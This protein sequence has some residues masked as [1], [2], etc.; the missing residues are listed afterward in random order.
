[1]K[2]VFF[3][4]IAIISLCVSSLT[5]QT[6]T[7]TDFWVTFG[8]IGTSYSVVPSQLCD[9]HVRIVG[10]SFPTSGT[11]YFTELGTDTTFNIAPYEVYTYML[12]NAEK[13]AVYN[14]TTGT[15]NFSIHIT[16]SN[17]VSIY[18]SNH[19]NQFNDISNVLPVT[20]LGTDY[21]AISWNN[22]FDS[23]AYA[24]IATENDTRVSHNGETPITLAAGQVYYRESSN[25]QTGDHITSDKPVAFFT[26]NR[27]VCIP[28][29][30]SV[31]DI[32][33]QQLAPVHTW[34]KTFFVPVTVIELEYVRIVASQNGTNIT[35]TGGILRDDLG[36]ASTL[37]NLNAGDYVTLE[38]ALS[39]NGCFIAAD[40]PVGVCSFMR[41]ILSGEG[42]GSASEAWIPAIEQSIPTV[43]MTPFEQPNYFYHYAIVITPTATKTNTTVSTEGSAPVLLSGGNWYDN[44]DAGMSFYNMP[45]PDFSASY[46]F[47]N[48]EGVMVFGYGLNTVAY[49]TAASSYYYLAGS[50]M[51]NLQMSFYVNGIHYEDLSSEIIT[52]PNINFHAEIEDWSSLRW[53]IDDV[54]YLPA[55]DELDWSITFAPGIYNLRMWAQFTGGNT[56]SISAI[57]NIAALI[58][59]TA[60]P[61]TAGSVTGTGY[62]EVGETATLTAIPANACY[63]FLYWA[64]EFD[65][66]LTTGN[67]LYVTVEGDSSFV[68]HFQLKTYTITPSV[69]GGN[70]AIAP[71]ATTSVDCGNNQAFTFTPD[72][73]YEL[74]SVS[75]DGST[76][77][78]SGIGVLSGNTFTF[79]NVTANHTL[80][81]T[82]SKITY[83]IIVLADPP[84]GGDVSGG[85]TNIGCDSLVTITAANN[86]CTIIF[87][88]WSDEND[89]WVSNDDT[90]RYNVHND[91]TFI[92]HFVAKEYD[93][94]ATVA[95]VGSGTVSG[96][97]TGII[98]GVEIDVMATPEDCFTFLYWTD[99]DDNWIS[100][101]DML[102]FIV[103]EDMNLVA[104]FEQ[105]LYDVVASTDPTD[106]GTITGDD[107]DI[108]CGTIIT[109]TVTENPGFTFLYWTD[110]DDNWISDDF[111]IDITV[112]ENH[113]LI[114]VFE[115]DPSNITVKANPITGGM[116][117][118]NAVN[119]PYGTERTVWSFPFN[120]Y[121]FVNWTDLDGSVASLLDTFTFVVTGSRTL[122]ANFALKSYQVTTTPNTLDMGTTSGDG[123]YEIGE[124]A[125]V[126]ATPFLPLYH[127]VNWTDDDG[128]VSN[129]NPYSFPVSRD[130][131]LTA[132]FAIQDF[133]VTVLPDP[134]D[135]GIVSGGGSHIPF[136]TLI[137]VTATP[138]V[139]YTFL[140]WT[141]N[142]VPKSVD[143]SY[144]FNVTQ[145]VTVVA[146]F[147]PTTCNVYVFTSSGA[148]GTVE[149]D[150]TNIPYGAW[151]TVYAYPNPSYHFVNWTEDGVPVSTDS[152]YGFIVHRS[153][154]LVANFALNT[155]DI[156]LKAQP[157][158]GGI[159][160]GGGT[161]IPHGT[162]IHASATA[163]PFFTFLYWTKENGDIVATDPVFDFNATSD[164][165]L[166]AHF[167]SDTFTVTLT[168]EPVGSGTLTGGGTDIPY[169]TEITVWAIPDSCHNFI[170]WIENGDT[171]SFTP[172]YTFEVIGNHELVAH[173]EL[174]FFRVTAEV[175]PPGAGIVSFD[176][177]YFNCGDSI[178]LIATPNI[179]YRFLNWTLEGV[180]VHPDSIYGFFVTDSVDLVAN[181][182]YVTYYIDLMPDP[183]G[184]GT[185]TQSGAYPLNFE[186]TV[187]AVANPEYTFVN[188]TE[189]EDTVCTTAN[190]TFTVDRDRFLVAHFE[191]ALFDVTVAPSPGWYA[192]EVYGDTTGLTYGTWH[193]I[194][195]IP[196]QYFEF[197]EWTYQDGTHF[198]YHAIDS[199]PVHQT[200]HLVAH[201]APQGCVITLG[202]IPT[203]GGE[204]TG[205]GPFAYG[206]VDTIRAFPASD[207]VF[208]KWTE[209]DSIISNS[210]MHYFTVYTSRHLVA[211]FAPKGFTIEVEPVPYDWGEVFGGGTYQLEQ[212]ANVSA[213]AFPNYAFDYWS[214]NGEI[215][216]GVDAVYPFPVTCDRHLKAHFKYETYNVLIAP[217]N[218]DYGW[219]DGGGF[220]IPWG[221]DTAVIAGPFPNY[222]F[223][224][225]MEGSD[226]VSKK[227][228]YD[229]TVKANHSFVAHF[230]PKMYYI[231]LV[232]EPNGQG[233]VDGEGY[234]A[235]LDT[236]T[237]T[238]TPY[239][240]Y[241][242]VN[243]TEN[244]DTLYGAGAE[245]TFT[246]NHSRNLVANFAPA[247]YNIILTVYLEEG[248]YTEGTEFGVPHGEDRTVHAIPF[249]GSH[250]IKWT[251]DDK[252]VSD[253]ADYTFTVICSRYLVAHFTAETR[254]ITLISIPPDGGTLT[255][256]GDIPLGRE[257]TISAKPNDCYE[258]VM[259]TEGDSIVS[260]EPDYTFTIEED[261]TFLA[262]FRKT[263]VSIFTEATPP[264]G[265]TVEGEFID[266]AC[267]TP[268]TIRAFPNDE[269]QFI[270][271]T[272]DGE[273]FATE[274]IHTFDA[275]GGTFVAH[276]EINNY[277]ITL[278]ADPPDLGTVSGGGTFEYGDTITVTA[279][280][281]S[282][283]SLISW[284]ENGNVVST[285]EDYTFMVDRSRTLTAHFE[286]TRYTVI[287]IA[288][289]TI[290]G[291]VKGGGIFDLNDLVEVQ[292]F[293][294]LGYMFANWTINDVVVSSKPV[295]E[296]FVTE[297]V[298]I[299]A[300]F[301]GLDFD[302]YA[303]TLWDNTFMLNMNK[304]ASKGY[305]IIGCKWFKNGKEE[306]HTNTI[307][308]FSY[309]A[310]PYETDLLELAPTYYMFML[311]T[312]N[313]TL[314]Y[315]TKKM[316]TEY[317]F[318]HE[319]EEHKIMVYP[320]PVMSGMPF[321]LEGV[322][323]GSAIEVYNQYGVCV[324]KI[325]AADETATLSLNLPA[326]VYII[327]N[328][329]KTTR[330]TIIR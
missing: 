288:N 263:N 103:E 147:I 233:T 47:S 232:A 203:I 303:A 268:V 301:Y 190:Y 242:F 300:N 269:Y 209:N 8:Q 292:A 285:D 105:Q 169:L 36:G 127:F 75:V 206:E 315:S 257:H 97:G 319:P 73:C 329:Y 208:V 49:S 149:G 2:K 57:V 106:A 11:I 89:N 81:V 94:L 168:A 188:W 327:R 304:L 202:R 240:G 134:E 275:V 171:V 99:E 95:P 26:L 192:G 121:Y 210:P 86:D 308:E 302:T 287:A 37:N 46:I 218:S 231:D 294:N 28:L 60:E 122:T 72:N 42:Q 69:I 245:Y 239:E 227:P 138:L 85:G 30:G 158:H 115:A 61:L 249:E 289:D 280:A 65:N 21:Y 330:I 277:T 88:H 70:G 133:S 6:T 80:D 79:N 305:D 325:N 131:D 68:A 226:T 318:D 74:N 52:T 82:F 207:Y 92:A 125:T 306:T 297:N 44:V 312:K 141:I 43:L 291:K 213:Q 282:G 64:D 139:G 32:I 281:K 317:R 299:V 34:G 217:N 250:F 216:S 234:Y 126:T 311:I 35:Q 77:I 181:F 243:W 150:T 272:R 41:S 142:D 22:G 10:G 135:G 84:T 51:R 259:W 196:A 221:T 170:C 144:S 4:L 66:V 179:G 248:G 254:H 298:T 256:G 270:N 53:F 145:S 176:T 48:P 262:H 62:Y 50:G 161:G 3:N 5:A 172:D 16:A 293:P 258:F 59:A 153:R 173:F 204:V 129:S 104:H 24:V 267:G 271:W 19:F 278:V 119:V 157:Q 146:H 223:L 185:A 253:D 167:I 265:G 91:S 18:A 198:S 225:W 76:T 184:T 114:A 90:L 67:P 39:N 29:F 7:G 186:L 276:F 194:T 160:S 117:G 251:E 309:S 83:E 279:S 156:I 321:K 12:D 175:N 235:F 107:T 191:D 189:D 295:Y 290:Y 137:T 212:T 193:T 230:K 182:E 326:G 124:L 177:A 199:F 222:D 130:R 247:S 313:G 201:F 200:L 109:V 9:M 108:P 244:G 241:V 323:K 273:E 87:S 320:N 140:Y 143:T 27:E 264:E 25:I 286:K 195:A 187:K 116:A 123:I 197:I 307:D 112:T 151:H 102:T 261:K 205:A 183:Y 38:I 78:P 154:D 228:R 284:T 316:L 238:A 23:D 237:I 55:Q 163:N 211:H 255:G 96:D 180:V 71:N 155:Y 54:E 174:M 20:A 152:T 58:E 111:S 93:I 56:M 215:L 1:M 118:G 162:T 136:G 98:C 31:D 128:W 219:V 296:F 224:C 322:V 328:K 310:G 40:K 45:L 252:L 100:D 101:D 214:E 148:G 33:F 15:T 178:T 165:T 113:T 164:T 283:F 246:V 220:D 324:S 266:V 166:I 159:V 229:L 260:E 314:M 236:A 63:E 274:A 17:P 110:E 14:T 13:D 132:N 120:D